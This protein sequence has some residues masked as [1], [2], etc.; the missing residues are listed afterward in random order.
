MNRSGFRFGARLLQLY[1]IL[2]LLALAGIWF[3]YSQ[4][5]LIRLSRS[6]QGYVH[7]LSAQL[8]NDTQLRSRMYAKFMSRATEPSEGGSPEL[9]IIFDEVI[10]KLDFPVIITVL[11]YMLGVFHHLQRCCAKLTML[12]FHI[13]RAQ[14]VLGTD[15]T[16]I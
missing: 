14:T 4:F 15:F 8:E 5:L 2:G 9:D 16:K 6:W 13:S 12:H 1:F 7:T 3:F 11:K 10:K